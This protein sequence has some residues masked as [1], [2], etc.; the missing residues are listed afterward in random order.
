MS[1]GF[2]VCKV[3]WICSNYQSEKPDS[4]RFF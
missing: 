2:N 4:Q 1:I 3:G